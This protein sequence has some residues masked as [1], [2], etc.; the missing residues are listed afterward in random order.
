MTI[1]LRLTLW[2][3]ALLGMALILFSVAVYSALSTNLWSQVRQD[4]ARQAQEVAK[5]ITFEVL[6]VRTNPRRLEVPDLDFFAS[7]SGVQFI[8]MSGM[9]QLRTDNFGT[10]TIPDATE[11][12]DNIKA[13]KEHFLITS[14]GDLDLLIYSTPVIVN[15]RIVGALQVVRPVT[16]VK[17]VLNQISRYLILGTGLSLILAAVIGAF[18][19]RR[20]LTP[21][22]AITVTASGISRTQDLGKRLSIEEDQSEVGQL[23]ATFNAM[24]DQIQ[25]LF[26]TQQRLI[27][28]V[29]HE[30][31]TPLTT[32]QGNIQLLQRITRVNGKTPA[33]D[34]Q[35]LRHILGEVEDETNRMGK[36]IADLLLLAQADS[37][38]A[39]LQLADVEM[40]TLVLDVY[41][42]SLKI[43]DR[44]KGAGQLHVV[45]SDEDQAM[46]YG[47]RERLRQLLLNL[48]E[49]AIKYTPAGGTVTIGLTQTED[50]VKVTV[51]DT[52]IGIREADQASIFERFYRTDKARS[53]GLGGSGLGL[54]IAQWIAEAHH[55]K[56]TVDSEFQKG[57]IFTLWLPQSHGRR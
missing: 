29:S 33:V 39:E 53:R 35:E 43:A 51:E 32:V 18:L 1:R 20:A 8:D 2:Y 54:S 4:A 9:V 56:I 40:D 50:W 23:A 55:G 31:R 30:L 28:D 16:D 57:S 37:G 25:S 52:G 38:A 11:A 21:I 22:D 47:D 14:S 6:I 5:A 15:Q 27:A 42:Q 24:L 34:P 13:G 41:R 45:L 26:D 12:L 17:N 7:S 19:A 36:M 46:I 3:T 10:R 49:N 48:V 44:E